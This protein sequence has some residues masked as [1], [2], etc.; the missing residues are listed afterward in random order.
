MSFRLHHLLW[1]IVAIIFCV[2]QSP[3]Y[4][5]ELFTE[6]PA[7]LQ[8]VYYGGVDWGDYDDDGDL[9]LLLTGWYWSLEHYLITKIYRNDGNGIF[10]D[11]NANLTGIFNSSVAWGDYNNNGSLDFIAAGSYTYPIFTGITTVYT[12]DWTDDYTAVNLNIL[13]VYSGS[14]QW[15]DYD[16]DGD[17]DLLVTGRKSYNPNIYLTAIY[18][19]DG[20]N[21]FREI[22]AGLTNLQFS[23]AQWGDYDN[24]GDL[25]ILV[26]GRTN[27]YAGTS[28]IYRNDG[29]NVFTDINAD[30]AQVFWGSI[31]WG[32]YD[33]DGDLD[34]L[35]AGRLHVSTDEFAAA[36]YRNDGSDVFT[37]IQAGLT[38]TEKGSVA[39]GDYDNDGDLDVLL[40]GVGVWP[41]IINSI[42]EN[43]GSDVFLLIEDRL[44]DIYESNTKWGDF[45]N[46]GDLDLVMTGKN[47]NHSPIAKLFSNNCLIANTA[48]TPP[49]NLQTE[50][51]GSEVLFSWDAAFD[52]QTPS[53]GLTYNLRLGTSPGACDVYSAIADNETGRRKIVGMGNVGHGL[54][55]QLRNLKPGVYYWSVQAIDTAFAGSQFAP[56]HSFVIPATQEESDQTLSVKVSCSP[57]PF[58]TETKITIN[59]QK[60]ARAKLEIYNVKGQ[61]VKRIAVKQLA[62]GTHSFSWDGKDTYGQQV[63]SGV[64]LINIS[65]G[66][67]KLHYKAV[68][69][70]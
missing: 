35:L 55:H 48:P 28:K 37:D 34:V 33:N 16:N 5:L 57:N 53:E 18:R 63:A 25:D 41:N 36:I 15:G 17:W 30:L 22:N 45:D 31:A 67:T 59:L 4:C 11:T 50:V 62:A 39:W 2:I 27:S 24:D 19:N 69:T 42:Y 49:S 12:N 10:T 66:S 54:T 44:L 8:G 14:V 68:Y 65:Q 13:G 60:E 58:S 20:N 32:D 47:R 1:I 7:G 29:N 56:E 46:D 43:C 23:K 26:I 21:V 70:K 51:S 6:V 64:Y 38:G 52:N 3:A 40:T 61:L 9:D